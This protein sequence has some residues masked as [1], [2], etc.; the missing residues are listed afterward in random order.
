MQNFRKLHSYF[1]HQHS[2]MRFTFSVQGHSERYIKE[3][4]SSSTLKFHYIKDCLEQRN[5]VYWKNTGKTK[6]R[7]EQL[8]YWCWEK[9]GER[10]QVNLCRQ[11]QDKSSGIALCQ[12]TGLLQE[13]EGGR[14]TNR[15]VV[16]AHSVSRSCGEEI[17]DV[18]ILNRHLHFLA[19][20]EC[21]N[22]LWA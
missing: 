8:V 18:N 19:L 14:S 2:Q 13:K 17:W 20:L 22:V 5:Q 16:C 4:L 15:S 1:L 12:R 6:K 3:L 21:L 10:Q 11:A 9:I 7:T